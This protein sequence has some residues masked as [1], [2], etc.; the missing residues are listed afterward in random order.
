MSRLPV[1]AVSSQEIY[2]STDMEAD[3]AIPGPAETRTYQ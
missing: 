1:A 2:V 3:G